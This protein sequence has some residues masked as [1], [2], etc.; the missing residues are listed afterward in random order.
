MHAPPPLH[1]F[2]ITRG[3]HHVLG[4]TFQNSNFLGPWRVSLHE[5]ATLSQR[6]TDAVGELVRE[7]TPQCI[8]IILL[9]PEGVPRV[10]GCPSGSHGDLLSRS[11]QPAPPTPTHG[12]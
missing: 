12:A 11:T 9:F 8:L 3:F 2:N 4:K 10:Q 1:S 7:S 5:C 6:P